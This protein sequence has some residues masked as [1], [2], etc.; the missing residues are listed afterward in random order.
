MTL[1][2]W[3]NFSDDEIRELKLNSDVRDGE[4]PIKDE[5]LAS[6]LDHELIAEMKTRGFADELDLSE[7]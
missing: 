5:S 1:G 4:I 3:S 6:Q 2:R 7:R